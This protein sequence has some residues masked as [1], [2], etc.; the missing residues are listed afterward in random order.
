[1]YILEYIHR[2]TYSVVHK[3]KFQSRF[4]NHRAGKAMQKDGARAVQKAIT[5]S[6]VEKEL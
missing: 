6:A 3:K 5:Q 1:M 2:Y 4:A